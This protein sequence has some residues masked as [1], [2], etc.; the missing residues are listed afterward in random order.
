[1]AIAIVLITH[2]RE[3]YIRMPE[4]TQD[5]L[6][7][8]AV[9]ALRHAEL[10][11]L[12]RTK[13]PNEARNI[14]HN[15]GWPRR[16]VRAVKFLATLVRDY[17]PG[18]LDAL[19]TSME[20]V[21]AAKAAPEQAREKL[22]METRLR[23]RYKLLTNPVDKLRFLL[24]NDLF[25]DATALIEEHAKGAC[26]FSHQ[27][28]GKDS[29]RTFLKTPNDYLNRAY[30]ACFGSESDSSFNFD[31]EGMA[32]TLGWTDEVKLRIVREL[33]GGVD[34]ME[35]R[36]S[37]TT[38]YAALTA[39]RDY[40]GNEDPLARD[41]EKR[42]LLSNLYNGDVFD[43]RRVLVGK[44]ERAADSRHELDLV[45]DRL[46]ELGMPMEKVRETFLDFLQKYGGRWN[47]TISL[48]VAGAKCFVRP[49]RERDRILWEQCITPY[50]P[51]YL[52]KKGSRL[53]R[54]LCALMNLMDL[55]EEESRQRTR[56]LV[57]GLTSLISKGELT[58]AFHTVLAIG[59]YFY[60]CESIESDLLAKATTFVQSL[61]P[62]AFALAFDSGE[63]G[64][65]AALVQQVGE[66]GCYSEDR[67]KKQAIES[68]K[69][70]FDAMA[71]EFAD[72]AKAYEDLRLSAEDDEL[73]EFLEGPG[74][75]WQDAIEALEKEREE[76]LMEQKNLR[77]GQVEAV[78]SLAVET[79]KPIRLNA[80]SYVAVPSWP[81][82]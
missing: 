34:R 11:R 62:D 63:Y 35:G 59:R 60:Y 51:H 15:S 39:A 29:D 58:L 73:E 71:S 10:V 30:Y 21:R 27:Y 7:K 20:Q 13:R 79:K 42:T 40:L 43:M 52:E 19:I 68:F 66:D 12:A 36:V 80:F 56:V 1:M 50:W 28:P 74:R 70:R 2:H 25:D 82:R 18:A 54:E 69:P 5:E 31:L 78:M 41:A 53:L 76:H 6:Q 8:L 49:D 47:L 26:Y 75:A 3:R 37:M 38:V 14:A 77:R 4:H 45:V 16:Q 55:R 72:V 24:E 67:L 64:I 17:G 44:P 33:L 46:V 9:P 48:A 65:A 32:T 57:G 22:K 61:I 81:E 23:E